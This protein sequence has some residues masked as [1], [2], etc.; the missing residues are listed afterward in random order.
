MASKVVDEETGEVSY[1][2]DVYEKYAS[3][4]NAYGYIPVTAELFA[5]LK[6]VALNCGDT[7]PLAWNEFMVFISGKVK[8]RMGYCWSIQS[9]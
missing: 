1:Y 3:Q 2:T 7:N 5:D 8:S 4:A 6:A 9:R